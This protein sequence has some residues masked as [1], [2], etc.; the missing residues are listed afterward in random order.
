M[1]GES[2]EREQ[3]ETS[4]GRERKAETVRG[5]A[6]VLGKWKSFTI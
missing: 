2:A 5:R 3:N 6:L 1:E 4:E